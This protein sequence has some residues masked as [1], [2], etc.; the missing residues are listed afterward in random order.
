MNEKRLK[1]LLTLKY[2]IYG[3]TIKDP[4]HLLELTIDRVENPKRAVELADDV[5]F[6]PQKKDK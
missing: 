4:F 3:E 1:D 5:Y 6:K 2:R